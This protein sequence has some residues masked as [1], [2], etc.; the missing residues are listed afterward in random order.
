MGVAGLWIGM[1]LGISLQAT[2]YTRL[3]VK[4]DW[5]LVADAAEKRINAD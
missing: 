2:F 3:V 4:T 5:Q 1:V